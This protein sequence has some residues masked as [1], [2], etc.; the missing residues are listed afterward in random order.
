[1]GNYNSQNLIIKICLYENRWT[2]TEEQKNAIYRKYVK[3]YIVKLTAE[4]KF[5]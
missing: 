5:V 4:K 1:M 3:C 2:Q